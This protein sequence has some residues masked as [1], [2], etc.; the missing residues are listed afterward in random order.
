MQASFRLLVNLWREQIARARGSIH[1]PEYPIQ[2]HM[3]TVGQSSARISRQKSYCNLDCNQTL[4]MKKVTTVT[5]KYGFRRIKYANQPIS[6]NLRWNLTFSC[7]Q[8]SVRIPEHA[9]LACTLEC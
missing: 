7:V 6:W 8:L 2:T 3:L 9:A 5:A 1:Q 4:F